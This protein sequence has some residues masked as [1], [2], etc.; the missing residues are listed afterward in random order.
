MALLILIHLQEPKL[1]K[2]QKKNIR[3]A[4]RKAAE[5]N[6]EKMSVASS[7][8]VSEM[9]VFG[10]EDDALMEIPVIEEEETIFSVL[11]E[12]CAHVSLPCPGSSLPL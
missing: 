8:V 9:D 5:R 1:S 12:E 6:N 10:T 3:R 2:A 4:E 11:K 7:E